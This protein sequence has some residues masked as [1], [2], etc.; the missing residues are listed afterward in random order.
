MNRCFKA[1]FVGLTILLLTATP[2]LA[3]PT[4]RV[5]GTDAPHP[6]PP[7]IGK[8]DDKLGKKLTLFLPKKLIIYNFTFTVVDYDSGSTLNDASGHGTAVFGTTACDS[9]TFPFKHVRI[10]LT[11]PGQNNLG[12]VTV[13]EI[14]LDLKPKVQVTMGT[15]TGAVTKLQLK[16]S[17]AVNKV[18]LEVLLPTLWT[19]HKL[20]GGTAYSPAKQAYLN[21]KDQDTTQD[22]DIFLPDYKDPNLGEV[23]IGDTNIIMDCNNMPLIVDLSTKQPAN[24]YPKLTGVVFDKIKTIPQPERQNTNAGFCFGEYLVSGGLNKNGFLAKLSLQKN[25][26]FTSSVPA[27]YQI[28]LNS[29][30]P[31]GLQINQNSSPGSSQSV[32]QSQLSLLQD[33]DTNQTQPDQ[34]LQINQPSGSGS[35]TP[36]PQNTLTQI[37]KCTLT[38]VKSAVLNGAFMAKV[39]LPGSVGT[40]NGSPIVCDAPSLLVDANLN[41][42]GEANYNQPIYWGKCLN[43]PQTSYFLQTIAPAQC[44]FPGTTDPKSDFTT[45]SGGQETFT[46]PSD[47]KKIPGVTFFSFNLTV[48]T[49][50]ANYQELYFPF[51]AEFAKHGIY[52]IAGGIKYPGRFWLNVGTAGM[53]G[54]INVDSKLAYDNSNPQTPSYP[55]ELGN[56]NPDDNTLTLLGGNFKPFKAYFHSNASITD[57]QPNGQPTTDCKSEMTHKFSKFFQ[58]TFVDNAVFDFG[59]DGHFAVEGPSNIF[60]QLDDLSATSTAELCS[61]QVTVD[62]SLDYWAVDLKT[63]SSRLVPKVT[64]VFFLGATIEELKHYEFGFPVVWGQMNSDGNI[65]IMLFGYTYQTFDRLAYS[66]REV[67]LSDYVND[68]PKGVRGALIIEGDVFFPYFDFQQM[69]IHDH[70]DCTPNLNTNF[71]GRKIEISTSISGGQDYFPIKKTWGS[72]KKDPS[73]QKVSPSAAFNFPRVIYNDGP[74]AEDGFIQ[75]TASNLKPADQG[76]TEMRDFPGQLPGII[77]ITGYGKPKAEITI[78]GNSTAHPV[79]DSGQVSL[80]QVR[81]DVANPFVFTSD[82]LPNFKLLGNFNGDVPIL[83]GFAADYA[84]NVRPESSEYQI[85]NPNHEPQFKSSLNIDNGGVKFTGTATIFVTLNNNLI[86]GDIFLDDVKVA[87]GPIAGHGSGGLGVSIGK[88]SQYIQGY[89]TVTINGIP[90]PAPNSG[91]GA[92]FLGYKANPDQIYAFDYLDRNSLGA[93]PNPVS[94]LYLACKLGYDYDLAG[95]GEAYIYIAGGMAVV[96]HP[97]LIFQAGVSTGIE[98]CGVGLESSAYIGGGANLP[99]LTGLSL[100]GTLTYSLSLFFVDFEWTG[101]ITLTPDGAST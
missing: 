59:I 69:T 39:T 21:I 60:A 43:Q 53:T 42:F 45:G 20:P 30:I 65:P 63:N 100:S 5:P 38:L 51:E 24:Y 17:P 77:H 33:D 1:V 62:A 68:N 71:E 8:E 58:A 93:I 46:T 48:R 27:G 95:L 75:S 76:F 26:T 15:M 13:G 10:E 57:L 12:R 52:Q 47:L 7:K 73:T 14:N 83:G 87:A 2:C 78:P 55:L 22:L 36:A 4:T 49:K 74:E 32:P 41:I 72:S 44:Y 3:A 23:G 80:Q 54:T 50:D 9:F 56:P 67:K 90:W 84:I 35:S 96:N 29:G 25:F 81:T 11:P 70:N 82:S 86:S 94:G 97:R 64:Q 61:A 40:A 6:P 66:Y 85:N 18:D 99:D 28:T 88:D 101:T 31:Q 92:F 89:A 91:G 16:A 98:V 19:R 79:G 34:G 37:S